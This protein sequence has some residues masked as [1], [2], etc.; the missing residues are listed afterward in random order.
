MQEQEKQ[1]IEYKDVEKVTVTKNGYNGTC[2][3]VYSLDNKEII[4]AKTPVFLKQLA[5]TV[6]TALEVFS[7]VENI[8]IRLLG[9]D[10][11]DNLEIK[12][13]IKTI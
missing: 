10:I 2:K 11:I 6:E 12:I 4:P 7:G 9:N 1:F 13:N 3:A 5:D 8:K